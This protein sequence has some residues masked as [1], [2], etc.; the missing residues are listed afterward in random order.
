[1]SPSR[2]SR[3]SSRR[4]RR[5]SAPSPRSGRNARGWST[6]SL[7]RSP[8]SG[9]SVWVSGAFDAVLRP[10]GSSGARRPRRRGV[11]SAHRRSDRERCPGSDR[12]PSSTTCRWGPTACSTWPGR[13]RTRRRAGGRTWSASTRRPGPI[14]RDF[15][16]PKLWSV[17]ATSDRI[18]AGGRRLQAYLTD[19][20]LDAGFAP[21]ELQVD[22]SLRD[23][24][25]TEQV[26]DLLLH[27]GDVIAVG[28]FDFINGQPQKVA[29][30]V[31]PRLGSAAGVDPRWYPTGECGV[32]PRRQG[33][34]RPPV[35]C[36]GGSDFTGA[37][38][39]A[40]GRQVWKTDTS[41]SSQALS[42]FDRSTLIVG[43]PLPVGGATA[44]SAMRR[45]R[46]SEPAVF[47]PASP[48]RDEARDRPRDQVVDA[49]DLLRLQRGV[50]TRGRS[51]VAPRCRGL[52][53][54]GGSDATGVRPV[55]LSRTSFPVAL[56]MERQR[57]Q[58]VLPRSSERPS[59]A[60][61][62]QR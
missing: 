5:P 45:Q 43:W 39:A 58:P 24:V 3:C 32:R 22:D 19:G 20:S 6:A 31:D 37:Y 27:G 21:V 13:S 25:A 7:A 17:L 30:R 12:T 8:W 33:A 9:G 51:A 47:P 29:V 16:T 49:T 61:N 36:G 1:M 4:H 59:V 53:A 46:P 28:K 54:G 15:S 23:H 48:G 10:N 26:R 60:T 44:G 62:R 40:G 34:W 35:R 50:G 18:Y 55:R 57:W 11:P 14:V 52:H 38:G 56:V 41:G 2:R 42:I